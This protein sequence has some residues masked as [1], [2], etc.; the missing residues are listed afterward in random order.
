MGGEESG[1]EGEGRAE[2]KRAGVEMEPMSLQ[3]TMAV[4][5]ASQHFA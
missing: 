3:L 5:F 1:R 2:K 4:Y